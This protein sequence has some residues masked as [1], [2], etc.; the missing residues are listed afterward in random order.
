MLVIAD[1]EK[2]CR[3]FD[4]P[5]GEGVTVY[6]GPGDRPTH[7]FLKTIQEMVEIRPASICPTNGEKIHCPYCGSC[8]VKA[9]T[10]YCCGGAFLP[11][12][13]ELQDRAEEIKGWIHDA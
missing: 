9:K 1:I 10:C 2:L 7:T 8:Q 11:W 4:I 3:G 13:F 5:E 12:Q 6:A